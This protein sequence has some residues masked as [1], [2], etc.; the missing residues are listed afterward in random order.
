MCIVWI[1]I[2]QYGF[3]CVRQWYALAA[4]LWT[5]FVQLLTPFWFAQSGYWKQHDKA[6]GIILC[7]H[8]FFSQ[9]PPK[10]RFV[11]VLPASFGLL[12]IG[13]PHSQCVPRIY[14]VCAWQAEISNGAR[15]CKSKVVFLFW[16]VRENSKREKD[17]VMGRKEKTEHWTWRWYAYVF[18][19]KKQDFYLLLLLLLLLLLWSYVNRWIKVL[20]KNVSWPTTG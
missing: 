13:R 3:I 6:C 17:E 5:P 9:N 14:S 16:I 7:F 10:F 11:Q 12:A 4:V 2:H 18:A 8:S 19:F 15:N 1:A 20:E